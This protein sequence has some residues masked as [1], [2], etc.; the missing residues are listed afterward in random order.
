MSL[1]PVFLHHFLH[2]LWDSFPRPHWKSQHQSKRFFG[3]YFGPV[4]SRL[5][6][7]RGFETNFLE[8]VQGALKNQPKTQTENQTG[9]SRQLSKTL[10]FWNIKIL[11]F[12]D[13][14]TLKFWD[15]EIPRFWDS[16]ILRC[17]DSEI[18]RYWDT[19]SLRFWD[20]QTL[21]FQDSEI[22]RY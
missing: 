3:I 15:T 5:W 1:L 11:K 16:Q 8:Q 19:E 13:S 18:L 10:R 17:Q 2:H 7:K 14:E 9:I 22:L 4:L 21:T 12:S 6:K 20:S